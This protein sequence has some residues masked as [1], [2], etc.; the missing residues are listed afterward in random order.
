MRIINKKMLLS[1]SDTRRTLMH[2]FLFTN[3]AQ[4]QYTAVL[5][6]AYASEITFL[7]LLPWKYTQEL[8]IKRGSRQNLDKKECQITNGKRLSDEKSDLFVFLS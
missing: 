3:S 1:S 8:D 7:A 5:K 2:L 6:N 4:R